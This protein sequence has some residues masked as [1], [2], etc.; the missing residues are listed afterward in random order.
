MLDS[1]YLYAHFDLHRIGPITNYK[2]RSWLVHAFVFR[3]VLYHQ[4]FG[5]FVL[6]LKIVE[7]VLE[8]FEKLL[9]SQEIKI[10]VTL[11]KREK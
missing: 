9:K 6:G 7:T 3:I 4:C 8:L 11:R 1:H 2:G 10:R 5:C